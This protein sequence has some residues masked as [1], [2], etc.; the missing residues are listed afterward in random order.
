MASARRS[1]DAENKSRRT[2]SSLR[3]CLGQIVWQDVFRRVVFC[4]KVASVMTPRKRKHYPLA[5]PDWSCY[6][7]AM[8]A[9][10]SFECGCSSNQISRREFFKT[11]TTGVAALAA[12][13]PLTGIAAR[14]EPAKT[15]A[16]R[17]GT[18]ETL[19]GTL[20][21]SFSDEQRKAICFPFDHPLRSK[22]DNHWFITDKT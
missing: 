12:A 20:Y 19:V 15:I 8:K 5:L 18:P 14:F 2:K 13:S 22:V 10:S 21:K 11:T 7:S 16:N 6:F 4:R 1:R 17:I 3:I 9:K